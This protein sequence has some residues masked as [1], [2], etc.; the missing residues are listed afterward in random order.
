ML[1]PPKGLRDALPEE[2]ERAFLLASKLVPHL[3]KKGY[4]LVQTPLL[5]YLETFSASG[6]PALDEKTLKLIEWETGK[7]MAGCGAAESRCVQIAT[8][9]LA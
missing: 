6:E 8:T 2:A 4:R 7:V 1:T 9:P 3:M 5:E